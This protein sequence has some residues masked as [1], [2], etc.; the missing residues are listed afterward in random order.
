MNIVFLILRWIKRLFKR[1]TKTAEQ[2][3]QSSRTIKHGRNP[4]GLFKNGIFKL[5]AEQ[6]SQMIY[7]IKYTDRS[8][9]YI[10]QKMEVSQYLVSAISSLEGLRNTRGYGANM[11]LDEVNRI[12]EMFDKGMELHEISKEV[13]RSIT[14]VSKILIA[15]EYKRRKKGMPSISRSEQKEEER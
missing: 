9:Q 14:V 8:I 13:R 11:P 15:C 12:Y 4:N 7:L 5:S 6:I 2:K 1:S 3:D 10:A